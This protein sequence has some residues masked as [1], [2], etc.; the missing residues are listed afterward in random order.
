MTP[1][2]IQPGELLVVLTIGY[3]AIRLAAREAGGRL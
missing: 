2:T 3:G 1:D